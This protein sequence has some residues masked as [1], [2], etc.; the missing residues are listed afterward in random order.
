MSNIR[1]AWWSAGIT[2]AVATKIA[3]E[4]YDNVIIYYQDAGMVHE[5]NE[6]FKADCER[7]YGQEIIT[8]KNSKGFVDHLDVIEKTGY[9]NGPDG[10]RCTLELKKNVRYEIEL[11]YVLSLFNGTTVG[12]QIFGYEFEQSQVNR[13]I[14]F[15]EQYP[16]TKPL[17]P[18]I[19]KGL[20]KD[21][22][23]A[24]LLNA[25]IDLPIMY[26]LGFSNNN[27]I[28]CVK[29][30][31]A[32]WNKIR[33]LFPHIFRAMA[34]LERKIGYS[35]IKG[36]FLDELEPERGNPGKVVSPACDHFC[37]VE[38]VDMPSLHLDDIMSGKKSIKELYLKQT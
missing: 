34:M 17:F 14:R 26:L 28:G 21:N 35:C 36:V 13:A 33:V 19:E 2:S 6:R 38:F 5:D 37:N 10:A 27:C 8:V 31:M 3:L 24:I 30:G 12:N 9:V 32:Y 7:W 25:G 20:T 1:I 15:I 18:L 4:Q 23:A 11:E 22:C 16:Y 29:G